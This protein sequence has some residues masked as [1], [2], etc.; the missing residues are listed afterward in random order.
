MTISLFLG[1][2][3]GNILQV[4]NTRSLYLNI[5]L[6]S[7]SVDKLAKLMILELA[8]FLFFVLVINETKRGHAPYK[9]TVTNKRNKGGPPIV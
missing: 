6:H 8:F 1:I 4:V 3:K 9:T 2:C 5:T 7:V